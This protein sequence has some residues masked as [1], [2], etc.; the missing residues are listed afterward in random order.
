[1]K[2][3][4]ILILISMVVTVSAGCANILSDKASAE[5]EIKFPAMRMYS[6]T[7]GGPWQV[8]PIE[9][10]FINGQTGMI[11]IYIKTQNHADVDFNMNILHS[12]SNNEGINIYDIN[13]AY[14]FIY[15]ENQDEWYHQDPECHLGTHMGP[16]FWFHWKYDGPNTLFTSYK[17]H[18]G[19]NY[20]EAQTIQYEKIDLYIS[21][22]T[23]NG[24]FIYESKI[25]LVGSKFK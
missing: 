7:E 19:V 14:Y 4:I 13:N 15:D 12:F 25:E 17:P 16:P 23:P 21:Q 3:I 8:E 18:R 10:E 6:L 24:I 9:F 20:I 11:T 1:M 22:W 5:V 2:A